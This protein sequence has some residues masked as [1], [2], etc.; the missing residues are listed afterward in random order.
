MTV[1]DKQLCPRYSARVVSGVQI[2]SS[3]NWMGRRLLAAGMRPINNIVDITNYVML[4]Y[5][6]PLHGFDYELVRSSILSCAALM[7][8]KR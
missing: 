3:P 2:G 5:G 1:E 8:A 7:K 6:Q 4:E